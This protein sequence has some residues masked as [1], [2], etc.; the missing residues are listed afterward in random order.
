[1]AALTDI[2]DMPEYD[3]DDAHRLRGMAKVFLARAESA[4]P[5]KHPDTDIVD[6]VGGEPP[7]CYGVRRWLI[8]LLVGEA[9]SSGGTTAREVI[10]AAR[11][12]GGEK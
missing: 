1:M 7:N 10:D 11:K 6:W 3:Q 12:Q 8:L 4:T 2:R 5:A 9:M